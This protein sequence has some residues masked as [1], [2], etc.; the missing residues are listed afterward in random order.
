MIFHCEDHIVDDT[1]EILQFLETCV[2]GAAL[3][4]ND[5]SAYW[6]DKT[7]A[8]YSKCMK[9]QT[10]VFKTSPERNKQCKKF[11]SEQEDTVLSFKWVYFEDFPKYLLPL[12]AV[13]VAVLLTFIT[14]SIWD[15]F[16]KKKRKYEYWIQCIFCQISSRLT[17]KCSS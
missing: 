2:V 11:F 9:A 3:Y 16:Q 14:G 15:C 12:G 13:I 8:E 7:Y 4:I 6:M 10:G 17:E 5:H 1:F